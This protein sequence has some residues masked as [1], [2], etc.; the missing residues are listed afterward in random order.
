MR[1]KRLVSSMGLAL[2]AL[3]SIGASGVANAGPMLQIVDGAGNLRLASDPNAESIGDNGGTNYPFAGSAIPAPGAGLPTDLGGWPNNFP[4]PPGTYPPGF[5]LDTGLPPGAG[6]YGISGWDASYLRLTGLGGGSTS[7][8]F[9]FMGKG[10]ASDHN[11]FETS[12]DGGATWTSILGRGFDTQGTH[13]TCAAGA[14]PSTGPADIVCSPFNASFTLVLSANDL[15][16]PNNDLLPFRFVNLTT[17]GIATNDGVGNI[18]P[19]DPPYPS[20]GGYHLGCD[21]YLATGSYQ[22]TCGNVY[23]GFT[24]RGFTAAGVGDHDYEDL[25]VRV[26][27]PEPGSLFLLGSGLLGLAGVRR[28]KA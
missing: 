23:A 1:T 5:D 2:A 7:V 15:I 18:S 3:G 12:L 8:T 25:I 17:P 16:G 20:Q 28:R 19:D 10:D 26:S 22:N 4:P 21:P 13:G 6:N 11:L 14:G 27:V 24:D 9:Q